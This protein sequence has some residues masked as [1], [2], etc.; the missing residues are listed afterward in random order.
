MP[1]GI[2]FA[3]G[4][5]TVVVCLA[6]AYVAVTSNSVPVVGTVRTAL[7]AM[8]VI[9][10]AGCAVAGIGQ[11]P[12]I[13]WT[14]PISILGIVLGVLALAIVAAGLA[15]WDGFFS[16]IVDFVPQQ[17]AVVLTTERLAMV[18]L[19]L[20]IAVKW[21]VGLVMTFGVLLPR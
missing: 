12:V 5:V 13:G 14:H 10:M 21:L 7:I 19:A 16:P 9:G 17:D 20:V 18:S 4:T 2:S 1:A 8:A 11:A 15:G 6:L 3:L